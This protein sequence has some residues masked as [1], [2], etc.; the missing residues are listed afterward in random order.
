M[1]QELTTTTKTITTAIMGKGGGAFL[2]QNFLGE[3]EYKLCSIPGQSGLAHSTIKSYLAAVG[4]LHIGNGREDP[5][6][7]GMA[8]KAGAGTKRSENDI[9]SHKK[10][11]SKTADYR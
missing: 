2:E 3:L 6:I 1:L 8:G 9:S 7:C 4:L 5:G 11:G 10:S